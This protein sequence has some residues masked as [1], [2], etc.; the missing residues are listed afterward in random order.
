[1]RRRRRAV[2][3]REMM[4]MRRASEMIAVRCRVRRRAERYMKTTG[5]EGVALRNV[6]H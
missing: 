6:D 5:R 1:M 4:G 3:E 2:R